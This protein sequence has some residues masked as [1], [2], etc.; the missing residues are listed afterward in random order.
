MRDYNYR[1][2]L[3]RDA[4]IAPHYKGRRGLWLQWEDGRPVEQRMFR[5]LEELEQALDSV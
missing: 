3:D 1:I 4:R 2:L 5:R